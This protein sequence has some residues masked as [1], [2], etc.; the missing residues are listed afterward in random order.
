MLSTEAQNIPWRTNTICLQHAVTEIQ[1][2]HLDKTL[3]YATEYLLDVTESA[4]C[5]NT[6]P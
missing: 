1:T 2:I 4:F 6:R 5:T 3:Y